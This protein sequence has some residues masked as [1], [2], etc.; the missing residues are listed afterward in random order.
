VVISRSGRINQR[1]WDFHFHCKHQEYP[2][3]TALLVDHGMPK[4]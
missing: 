4:N 2:G 1:K 3:K